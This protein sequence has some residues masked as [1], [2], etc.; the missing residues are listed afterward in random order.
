ML[1]P[2]TCI[3]RI[4]RHGPLPQPD[5]NP[6]PVFTTC[7]P[8]LSSKPIRVARKVRGKKQSNVFLDNRGYPD[9][10]HEFDVILHNVKGG[11]ILCWRKH[12]APPI[13]NIDPRFL[14]HYNE[15]HHG[16]KL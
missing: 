15:A 10:S 4:K 1:H 3:I 6:P 11:P 7:A 9:Q 8:N 12:P 2:K 13:D 16:A 14:L 5:G